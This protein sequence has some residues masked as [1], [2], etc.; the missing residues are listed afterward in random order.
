MSDILDRLVKQA[1]RKLKK[2][3]LRVEMD[4][5]DPQS[6]FIVGPQGYPLDS[7]AGTWRFSKLEVIKFSEDL[8][9]N[10]L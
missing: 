1:T 2:R 9:N 6:F 3:G 10:Q 7:P 4:E 8:F 5:R